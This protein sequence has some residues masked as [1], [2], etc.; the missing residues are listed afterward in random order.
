MLQLH[1][2]PVMQYR[3]D[4]IQDTLLE[5]PLNLLTL[6]V[7]PRL[8]VE[9]HEGAEVEPGLLQQLDLADVYL[10]SN[11]CKHKMSFIKRAEQ[12]TPLTFCRG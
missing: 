2:F 1:S 7:R 6:V 10:L 4:L 12:M 9:S 5:L 8:A 3:L 11:M